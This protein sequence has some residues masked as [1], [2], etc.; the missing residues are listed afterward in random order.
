[1][2]ELLRVDSLCAGY[3]RRRVLRDVSF[4]VRRGELC[5]LL[6]A[7][8]SGK[9]TLLRALCGLTDA[10]E[11]C[12]LLE[13]ES[14]RDMS[15]RRRAQ[16]IGYLAQRSTCELA[17]S[18]MDVV[19]MGCN[20]ALGPFQKPGP[21]DRRRAMALLAA[22]GDASWAETGYLSLSEGQRQLVLFARTLVRHSPLLLLDEPD[23]ALDYERRHRLLRWLKA[24]ARREAAGVLLSSHD[25]NIALRYADRLLLL[26]DG[27]LVSQVHMASATV[28]SLEEAL[29]K[30]YGPVEILRHGEYFLMTR[31][32]AE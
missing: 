30:I 20:P 8:G 15:C 3:G 29:T 10:P 6:G 23:S 17:L 11:G 9:S 28:G 22:L 26:K 27:R 2:D 16:R 25:A 4:A 5:A 24:Y 1:M 18:V 19:L 7:N 31:G 12:M 14:L 13:A 21:E 32:D